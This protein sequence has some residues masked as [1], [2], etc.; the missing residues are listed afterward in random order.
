LPSSFARTIVFQAFGEIILSVWLCPHR[1]WEWSKK[2]ND[3]FEQKLALG[4]QETEM[5]SIVYFTLFLQFLHSFRIWKYLCLLNTNIHK[6][7]TKKAASC[8]YSCIFIL[9]ISFTKMNF[10]SESNKY[11]EDKLQMGRK[12]H[13]Q[14]CF[15]ASQEYEQM[16]MMVT[17]ITLCFTTTTN[18]TFFPATYKSLLIPYPLNVS[19]IR[20]RKWQASEL[21]SLRWGN[22]IPESKCIIQ[23]YT[24]I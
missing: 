22:S 5:T 1:K 16:M 11:L 7:I 18:T 15:F 13:W 19:L 17:M 23:F 12:Q 20:I 6:I 14:P 9:P 8:L 3:L 10:S 2:D 24:I 4:S 21:P